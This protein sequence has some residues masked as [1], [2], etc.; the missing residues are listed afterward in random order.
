MAVT[1]RFEGLDLVVRVPEELWT[2]VRDIVQEKGIKIH[3]HGKEMQK[4]KMAVWGGLTNSCEKKTSERQRRKGKIY[5]LQAEKRKP[6]LSD[7]CKETEENNRIGK[8]RNLFKKIRSTKGNFHAKMDTIKDR[9]GMDLTEAED[10][11]ER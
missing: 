8:T 7:Q 9:N 3:P 1:N 11:K 4:S 5:P 6:S 10:I 2:E